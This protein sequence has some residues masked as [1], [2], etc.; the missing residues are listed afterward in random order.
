MHIEV[1][2]DMVLRLYTAIEISSD[3][4]LTTFHSWLEK[5]EQIHPDEEIYATY[6]LALREL[7]VLVIE[8]NEQE[9]V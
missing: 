6:L 3:K 7:I 4:R 5:E 9:E 1:F 8:R 2:K